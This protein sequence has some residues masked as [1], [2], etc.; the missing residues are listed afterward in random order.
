M[1]SQ[2]RTLLA[3]FSRPGEN[4]YYGGRTTLAV[5]NTQVVAGLIAEVL[6]VDVHQ[7]TAADP[8]SANYAQTVARNV[9]EQVRNARPALAE[10]VPD[11][12]LYDTVLIG[13]P[14]WNVQPPMIMKTFVQALDL[15]GK[16]LFPFTTHAMSGLGRAVQFYGDAAPRARIGEGL[17]VRGEEAA[18]SKPAITT[19]LRAIGVL[20]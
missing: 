4:Y 10:P 8:Y 6:F 2:S 17:A 1:A 19:W 7:L 14:I 11:I 5:G 16:T 18:G 9:D 12:S 13:S 3:F 20:V 15:S